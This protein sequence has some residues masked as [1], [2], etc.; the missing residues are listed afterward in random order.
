MHKRAHSVDWWPWLVFRL[1]TRSPGLQLGS[2]LANAME[3]S[4]ME[5]QWGP[6]DHQHTK[7][8]S[9]K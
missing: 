9:R 1:C 4:R 2:R 6:A 5:R 7:R 3:A 8:K